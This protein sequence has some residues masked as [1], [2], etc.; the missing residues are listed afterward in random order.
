MKINPPLKSTAWLLLEKAVYLLI[1]FVVTLALARYLQPTQFGNLNYLLAL[2]AL[3][4]PIM[5]LGLNSI[6]SR[7]LLLRPAAADKIMGSS[8]FL[9][10]IASVSVVLVVVGF[11]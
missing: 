7:E 10:F 11:S 8:L 6:V 5:S 9:R 2:I 1:S 4:L 3:F